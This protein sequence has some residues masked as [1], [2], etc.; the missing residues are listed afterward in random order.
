MVAENQ[1]TQLRTGGEILA[2]GVSFEEYL[3][4][5]A[6]I[7]C[8]LVGGVVIKMSPAGLIHNTIQNY[9]YML[10]SA[11]FTLRP[12][13]RVI[14]QPFTQRLPNVEPKREPDLLVILNSNPH[15]LRETYMDGPADICIEIVSPDSIDRDRGIKFQEYETGGVPEYWILDPIHREPLF[16]H[17]N[18]G[19]L[20]VPQSLDGDGNYQPPTLPDLMLHIPT[21]WNDPL[22]NFYEIAEAVKAMLPE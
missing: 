16:Y 4:K 22:P 1:L 5:F 9:L 6:G 2:T 11:Y 18:D 14:S 7:H 10:L 20:Y 19:G 17:L 21:L 3:E 12:I 13:G 15:V 8:E